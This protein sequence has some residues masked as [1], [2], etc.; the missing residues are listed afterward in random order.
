MAI[1]VD[2]LI[3]A[4]FREVVDSGR[5]ASANA[6]AAQD[7]DAE[8][9]RQMIKSA[10]VVS[11][12]GER[13]LGRIRPLWDSQVEKHG[14]TFKDTTADNDDLAEERRALEELLYDFEDS[15]EADTF[16]P[17]KFAEVQAA[18]RAFALDILDFV[19]RIKIETN[20]PTT[21]VLTFPPLP[22]LPPLPSNAQSPKHQRHKLLR[23]S[24]ASTAL[25]SRSS[26][27]I[28]PDHAVLTAR[29]M[30]VSSRNTNDTAPARVVEQTRLEERR[31][32]SP[33][34]LGDEAEQLKLASPAE[35]PPAQPR[36]SDWLEE[37][38]QTSTSRP[39]QPIRESIPENS[40]VTSRVPH[41]DVALSS[42]FNKLA[43]DGAT[44]QSSVF[45][46]AQSINHEPD[47]YSEL[48]LDREGDSRANLLKGPFPA[49]YVEVEAPKQHEISLRATSAVSVT[50]RWKWDPPDGARTGWL[51]FGKGEP[52]KNV[53]WLYRDH[54]CWSGTDSKGKF[55][56]FPQSRVNPHSLKEGLAVSH[57]KRSQASGPMRLFSRRRQSS[58]ASS[59]S[60]ET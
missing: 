9:A 8:L 33:D 13:A 42:R 3:L 41:D 54:W 56:I 52:I 15:I 49:K 57:A 40:A 7:E 10:Q 44:P 39:R 31:A 29:P 45:D 22:P 38:N 60:G 30:L 59:L 16:D 36:M 6:E 2:E 48:A 12:E 43:L 50:T 5:V 35:P 32:S 58:T 17:A 47:V 37:Q 14:D 4:P 28:G 19:K 1:H 25:R 24:G 21:P 26:G 20:T 11:K 18:T 46:P 51:A 55:G 53:A 34:V 27:G 23:R